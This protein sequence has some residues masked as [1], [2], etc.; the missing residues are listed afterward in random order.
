MAPF[1]VQ[2]GEVF[3]NVARIKEGS[4]KKGQIG[5]IGFGQ[6]VDE[7]NLPVTTVAGKLKGELIEADNLKV[8]EA[9]TFSGDAKSSNYVPGSSGWI[10]KQDGFLEANNAQIR[11]NVDLDSLT[12]N[13]ELP[14]AG[15][16][17]QSEPQT[18]STAFGSSGLSKTLSFTASTTFDKVPEGAPLNIDYVFDGEVQL[19]LAS[20]GDVVTGYHYASSESALP[21]SSAGSTYTYTLTDPGW[22]N[23]IP[24]T[25]YVSINSG[26]EVRGQYYYVSHLYTEF[27]G[28]C[29]IEFEVFVD[30]V[31]VF[32]DSTSQ[33]ISYNLSSSWSGSTADAGGVSRQTRSPSVRLLIPLNTIRYTYPQYRE[34]SLVEVVAK[35]SISG[36]RYDEGKPPSSSRY[37]RMDM[38]SAGV[39]L[40]LSRL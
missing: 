1:I 22:S 21:L 8:A 19:E 29:F 17:L 34:Q 30:G 12:V 25:G 37:V 39:S 7:N 35:V 11:G 6:I 14:E 9:A 40:D 16:S 38:R 15:D 13:G 26:Y 23:T 32:Q 28:S 18:Y 20:A 33:S 27:R 5:A 36:I 10:L 3:I 4:I 2:G 24:N 31:S